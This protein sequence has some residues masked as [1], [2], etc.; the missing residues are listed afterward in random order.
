MKK[1]LISAVRTVFFIFL[2]V[3]TS[4]F[5]NAQTPDSGLP[6]DPSQWESFV[7][8]PVHPFIRDTFRLQTFSGSAG[9]T[10][11]Y[12]TQGASDRF[13][14]SEEGVENQGGNT[15]IR[16][17]P[18]SEIRF[19]SFPT[20]HH[21]DIKINFRYA[22]KE[23]MPG[24]NLLVSCTRPQGNV[25]DYPQCSVT[26]THFTFSY[27]DAHSKNYGQIG[28]NPSD[29]LL[30]IAEGGSTAN[31]FYC[32]D[33]VYAHGLISLYTL[34]SGTGEW[35]TREN[36]SHLAP[37]TFRSALVNGQL[38]LKETA[39]CRT[40]AI[41]NGSLLLAPKSQL[42]VDNLIFHASAVPQNSDTNETEEMYLLSEGDLTVNDRV[43]V[44]RTFPQTGC[45]YFFSMPFD[46]YLDGLDPAFEWKDDQKNNGGN[47]FYLRHYDGYRRATTQS[48]ESNWE[49]LRPASHIAG[50]PVLHKNQGY[51]I[52]L[53]S[54]ADRRTL[55]F[56]SAKGDTPED[57]G[58]GGELSLQSYAFAGNENGSDT[59]WNLCG[60][61]FPAA[62]S[63][64]MLT[65][66]AVTDGYIYVYDG[67]TYRRY[68]FGSDYELPPFT[69]F[70]IKARKDG[71]LAWQTAPQTS[72]RQTRIPAPPAFK[73][74][75]REP[76]SQETVSTI[77]PLPSAPSPVVSLSGT[78]L[79][80]D[81]M[82]AEVR[83]RLNDSEGRL[84]YS[85][86]WPAGHSC[87]A[88]P[89]TK[90]ICFLTIETK[91]YRRYYK[92]RGE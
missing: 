21:T 74:V 29:L 80:L 76:E 70:F 37:S 5:V 64:R 79:E 42:Q 11:N 63:L 75:F 8:S 22:A 83:V 60:N 16:L 38:T 33:S 85:R 52:A 39:T 86:E 15:S 55:C 89:R 73:S 54:Q 46:V 66:D 65:T 31:G 88:L 1:K 19:D 27:P 48:A 41:G 14:A 35:K 30:R 51:L 62:L 61:P 28:G 72:L 49:V 58:R 17:K 2:P 20:D 71:T 36:W 10:W 7:N 23:L 68:T 82:P 3:G 69:A 24:E 59:G 13:D 18:G 84:L 92:Y 57:F 32:L 67:K 9:D 81:R 90:G 45:W 26:S 47:Y 12:T 91:G 77:L 34:F 87:I 4:L 25:S 40:I 56:T 50:Q 6:P 43:S 53:D 44:Y 78:L